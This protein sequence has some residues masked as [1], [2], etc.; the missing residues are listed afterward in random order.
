M[1]RTSAIVGTGLVCLLLAAGAYYILWGRGVPDKVFVSTAS[2]VVAKPSTTAREVPDGYKEYRSDFYRL[3]FLYPDDLSVQE[4]KGPDT[5]LTVSFEDTKKEKGFQVFVVPYG[6]D[7]ISERRFKLDVPSGVR[8]EPVD[9]MVDGTRASA[10]FSTNATLG[11][12]REV[13]FIK[14]GF[15]Y[16]V[17]TYKALDTWLAGIMQTWKFL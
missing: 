12:T 2:P 4:Y 7:Q 17:T 13:W 1:K 3:S 6:S 16:E 9:V 14:N 10:F 8:E 5:T 11:D 15:L